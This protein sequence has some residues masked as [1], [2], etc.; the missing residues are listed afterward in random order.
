MDTNDI[1][2]RIMEEELRTFWPQWHVVKR[3]GEGAF[4]DVF[5][6]YKDNYGIR[7]YAALK[8]IQIRD[9][10]AEYTVPLPGAAPRGSWHGQ[11]S[12]DVQVRKNG[13]RDIPEV[14]MNEIRIME[15]M[16]GAPNIVSIDDF[17]FQRSSGT[18]TL[19]VRMEF[20]TS[21]QDLM[22][23]RLKN[24]SPFTIEDVLK[25]GKDICTALMHCERRG[26]IHRDI[27]P[28]NLFVDSYGNYKVGDFGASKRVETVHATLTMTGIGTFSYMAPEIFAGRSYN[29]TVDIYAV[30]IVLYQLLNNGRMPFLP[31]SGY[32]SAQDIDRA[33]YRRLHGEN[34]PSLA[35]KQTGSETVDAQLDG[36]ICKACSFDIHERYRTAK[37]FYDALSGYVKGGRIT[38]RPVKDRRISENLNKEERIPDSYF[39]SESITG[40]R[41]YSRAD[42]YEE[43]GDYQ[44]ALEIL[45]QNEEKA[46]DDKARYYLRLGRCYRLCGMYQKALECYNKAIEINP[47][48]G[49]AYTNIGSVYIWLKEYSRALSYCR[50]GITLMEQGLKKPTKTEYTHCLANYAIALGKTGQ[51]DKCNEYFRKAESYGYPNVDKA[52]RMFGL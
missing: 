10:L 50:K 41:F 47:N 49:V 24:N 32:Y 51:I 35:G 28:A 1:R 33:N 21:F 25:I 2:C 18:S 11:G 7:V 3:L 31:T 43:K 44:T 34:V 5:Q 4:G 16:R 45:L 37:E 48:D 13:E 40:P 39:A 20:L 6:I 29:N 38:E 42:N 8:V 27:K 17:Y 22:V 15:A 46:A 36:I 52:R 30:G 23:N 12:S 14:F 19:Y 26:I 9:A